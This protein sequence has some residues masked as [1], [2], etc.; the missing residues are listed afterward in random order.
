M[1]RA[2]RI[3]LLL[4]RTTAVGVTVGGCR[5]GAPTVV[6]QYESAEPAYQPR[7]SSGS[8]FD[9][10]AIAALD[11]EA[12]RTRYLSAVSF[13]PD[14]QRK[15]IAEMNQPMARIRAASV[16]PCEYEFRAREPFAPVP[17]LA[18]WR[19][20]G[21]AM[22]WQTAATAQS[23][24][25]DAAIDT[26]LAATRFGFDLTQGDAMA[27]NLGCT[28]I[29]DV[30]V[31]MLPALPQLSQAQLYRLAQGLKGA[32]AR[33]PNLADCA[34][35]EARQSLVAAQF[36]YDA[37][38]KGDLQPFH[39]RLG[40]PG[41]NIAQQLESLR[42]NDAE[43]AAFMEKYAREARQMAAIYVKA[44]TL[45]ASDRRQLMPDPPRSKGRPW[46]ILAQNFIDTPARIQPIFDRTLARTR[47]WIIAAMLERSRR[48]GEP[49]PLDLR[50]FSEAVRTDPYSGGDFG[51]QNDGLDYKL[52]ANGDN[53][54]ADAGDSDEAG[55]APDLTLEKLP[56]YP[57]YT[58]PPPIPKEATTVKPQQPAPTA[59]PPGPKVKFSVQ[60]AP[61]G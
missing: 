5:G 47:M 52:Y 8:T 46:R 3:L 28:I 7:E 15:V 34:R 57:V 23:G 26:A 25:L 53:L 29:N 54:T 1:N 6:P 42:S 59:T 11:V 35:Y 43:L 30:R 58:A 38:R 24:N 61:S 13:T 44:A 33:G 12:T 51:Y 14:Q 48:K 31:A 37:A 36:T 2:K 17:F 55:L 18:G 20:I 50:K 56:P 27:A 40:A 16:R 41:D 4:V 9:Q 19:L 39:T 10:Y 45:P 21:R 32:A 22:A 60:S 49:F